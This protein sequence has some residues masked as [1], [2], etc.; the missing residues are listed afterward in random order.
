VSLV[1]YNRRKSSA[2]VTGTAFSG[3]TTGALSATKLTVGTVVFDPLSTMV[4]SGTVKFTAPYSRFYRI[5]VVSPYTS[6]TTSATSADDGPREYNSKTATHR[7]RV[8]KNGTVI[9]TPASS[10]GVYESG[11]LSVSFSTS[12]N[13]SVYVA[14]IDTDE[15]S[16]GAARSVFTMWLESGDYLEFDYIGEVFG[17]LT[18]KITRLYSAPSL[19]VGNA[20]FVV[21]DSETA[22]PLTFT[23]DE[24][25][26]NVTA[27]STTGA[28]FGDATVAA[29]Y[30]IEI[31]ELDR[32]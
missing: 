20:G 12:F 9:T 2:V 28:Y 26:F 10:G 25:N 15:T 30:Y 6:V 27:S 17:L 23:M 31:N 1:N 14:T 16:Y 32:E 5:E 29:D 21:T 3:K 8:Y 11:L 22:A 13:G 4:T 24:F 18:T 19:S 7:V